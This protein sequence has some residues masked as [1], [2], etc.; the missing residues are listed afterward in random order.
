MAQTHII[1]GILA[2]IILTILLYVA[3]LP[4]S[5]NGKLG[6]FGQFLHDFFTFK[7][8]YIE[9]VLRFLYVLSTMLC[10]AIGFFS[11]FGAS[12]FSGL[13]LMILGPI[14][15]RIAYELIMLVI[16][17]VS[18][19]IAINRKLGGEGIRPINLADDSS[20]KEKFSNVV[21]GVVQT[22]TNEVQNQKNDNNQQQ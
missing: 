4:E 21:S 7:K 16:I 18:N 9:A 12:F 17:L 14:V 20:F 11:M 3:V 15:V 2:A 5:K 8:L 13:G 6:K 1:L 10:I 22:V 19:V